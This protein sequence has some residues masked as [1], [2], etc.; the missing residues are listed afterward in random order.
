MHLS[1]TDK[2]EDDTVISSSSG[3]GT[4]GGS[5][6]ANSSVSNTQ[7]S[8]GDLNT[9]G[10]LFLDKFTDRRA[11][12]CEMKTLQLAA[13]KQLG[14]YTFAACIL[15]KTMLDYCFTIIRLRSKKASG[16]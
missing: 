3:L 2:D 14:K 6:L 16:L 4:S 11:P 8:S 7:S 15:L 9:F 12:G 5:G 13:Q 10:H 1:L